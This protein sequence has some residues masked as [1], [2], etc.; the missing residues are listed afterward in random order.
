M[1][2]Q[3]PV[4]SAEKR[5]IL[6]DAGEKEAFAELCAI[7]DK[8]RKKVFIAAAIIY[9]VP[10]LLAYF[11]DWDYLAILLPAYF[12][13]KTVSGWISSDVDCPYKK[14]VIPALLKE[15]DPGLS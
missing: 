13:V 3:D 11:I 2:K 15:I 4:P 5:S 14:L 8:T 10:V 9:A 6:L 7:R 1:T 12:L